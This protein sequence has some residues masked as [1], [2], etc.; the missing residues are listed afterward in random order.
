VRACSVSGWRCIH[1]LLKAV[2]EPHGDL[3]A[4]TNR[5]RALDAEGATSAIEIPP[6]AAATV[7]P[8]TGRI[9][10]SEV[11]CHGA[12]VCPTVAVIGVT[13]E[14][15]SHSGWECRRTGETVAGDLKMP[16]STR[17]D[18]QLKQR[19]RRRKARSSFTT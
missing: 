14:G 1:G 9:V 5:S 4:S 3:L 19:A 11:E 13:G 15:D 18:F 7:S 6:C 12:S 17:L 10:V 8:T 2:K 16:G